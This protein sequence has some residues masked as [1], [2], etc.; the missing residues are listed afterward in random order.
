MSCK[1]W[2]LVWSFSIKSQQEL[3]INYL[4]CHLV[5]LFL[6]SFL[7]KIQV[8]SGHF[9]VHTNLCI[10]MHWRLSQMSLLWR[11]LNKGWRWIETVSKFCHPKK[12]TEL[13][14]NHK[15][16]PL[17]KTMWL[18]RKRHYIMLVL[19]LFTSRPNTWF[20]FKQ[21]FA[22]KYLIPMITW[23]LIYLSFWCSL[24]F[25]CMCFIKYYWFLMY[26]LYLNLVRW[27]ALAMLIE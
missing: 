23:L 8:K 12:E 17:T 2:N 21:L 4:S 25:L 1:L 16:L 19:L 18:K 24:I 6:F 22:K 15:G 10:H 27:G 26:I 20:W 11:C 7:K 5:H 3:Q 13:S 14:Q 9:R